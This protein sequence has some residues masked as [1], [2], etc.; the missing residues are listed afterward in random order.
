MLCPPPSQQ[1]LPRMQMSSEPCSSGGS[2]PSTYMKNSRKQRRANRS[3]KL[4]TGGGGG[5]RGGAGAGGA[6]AAGEEWRESMCEL[7]SSVAQVKTET[8]SLE[9][10]DIPGFF[11]PSTWR[12]TMKVDP[13][14]FFRGF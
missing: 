3:Q 12:E 13:V 4:P 10:M 2:G 14:P 9:E 5:G 7:N 1:M 6:G 8:E 11:P